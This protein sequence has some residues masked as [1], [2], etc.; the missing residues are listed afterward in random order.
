VALL[1]RNDLTGYLFV[2][3]AAAVGWS[4]LR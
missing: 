3:C 4:S 1:P 2:V